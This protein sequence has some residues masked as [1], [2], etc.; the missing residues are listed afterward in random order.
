[1]ML[2][3][4]EL[5]SGQ[6]VLEV[7]SGCGY[8]LALLSEIVGK[9]GRIFGIEIVKELVEDSKNNLKEY[10]NIEVYK[11]NGRFENDGGYASHCRSS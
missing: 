7:G 4:L 3:L 11:R 8:V 1:M 10:K 2:S 9:K 6:R 5:E